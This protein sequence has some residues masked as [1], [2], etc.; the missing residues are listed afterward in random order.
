MAA[1]D[2]KE[3]AKIAVM[4]ITNLDQALDWQAS[5]CER[6][7]AP[8]TARLIRG[9][10]QARKT[11]TKTADRLNNWLGLSLE[12]ALPLRLVGGMRSLYLN[13]HDSTLEPVYTGALTAQSVIDE[14]VAQLVADHDA[15]LSPWLDGPPQTNEAGRSAGVMA[16][17][18]WLSTRLGSQ[19]ELMEIGASAGINT[20]MA[21]YSYDLGGVVVGPYDAAIHIQ[22]EWR[23]SPPPQGEVAIVSAKGCD[24]APIDLTD[25]EQA[26]RL[27]AYIWVDAEERM[28]RMDAAIALAGEKKPDLVAQDAA[29]FVTEQL[30]APQD[31]G[32]TRVL[33]HTVMWQ[34]LPP[35]TR[36]SITDAMVEAGKA[37]TQ[38]RPL[39][40][41]AVET[42][43]QT[44][45]HELKVRFWPGQEEPVMLAEAHPH[46]AWVE[47]LS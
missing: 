13:G 19:F 42:N 4:E 2:A 3:G 22:P 26:T 1:S 5:H 10:K 11:A 41:I 24:L 40:W 23:G 27:K 12:D 43:R 7:G 44:F 28:A 30:Q 6:A 9:I 8:R 14:L 17:L 45:K 31:E 38:D 32:V 18:L 29:R 20:M 34:Y 16:G 25:P 21:R 35:A 46:G 39:A 37:A 15:E 36:A 47:W 33:V